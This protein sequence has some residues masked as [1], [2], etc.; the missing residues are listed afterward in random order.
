MS[1]RWFRIPDSR[2][3]GHV[4]SLALSHTR[5]NTDLQAHSAPRREVHC[6]WGTIQGQKYGTYKSYRGEE[7]DMHMVDDAG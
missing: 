6:T 7:E 4:P 2:Y 1:Y 3:T 5:T